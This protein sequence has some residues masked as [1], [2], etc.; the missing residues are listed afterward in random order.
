MD[1]IKC[2]ERMPDKYMFVLVFADNKGT[3]EPKPY[4]IARW[5]VDIW[6]F[7]NADPLETSYGAWVDIEYPINSNNV[8]H[9]M[10][11][12]KPPEEQT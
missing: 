9:W 3:C 10:P 6:G 2:S 7:V 1:W 5:E 4:C 12:P 11:L 8:T